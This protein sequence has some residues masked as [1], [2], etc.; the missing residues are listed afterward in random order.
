MERE[1]FFYYEGKSS[2][3]T[4]KL[5]Y[6]TNI[7]GRHI[8]YTW[9]HYIWP[10]LKTK[11]ILLLLYIMTLSFY[12]WPTHTIYFTTLKIKTLQIAAIHWLMKSKSYLKRILCLFLSFLLQIN[13]WYNIIFSVTFGTSVIWIFVSNK[14]TISD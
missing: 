7:S 8:L 4:I 14:L 5:T 11:Y 12:C 10:T 1:D 13:I 2:I 3:Y 9:P 6:L